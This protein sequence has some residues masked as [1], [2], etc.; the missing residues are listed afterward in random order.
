MRR[1]FPFICVVRESERK[2]SF[3][4]VGSY[5]SRK[6]LAGLEKRRRDRGQ[7]SDCRRDKYGVPAERKHDLRDESV[8]GEIY[9]EQMSHRVGR[10]KTRR[11]PD[12]AQQ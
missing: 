12:D 3:R 10:R 11:D 7:E 5:R 2:K 8:R 9:P 6:H 4:F 1:P